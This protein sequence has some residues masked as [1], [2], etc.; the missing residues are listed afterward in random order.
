MSLSEKVEYAGKRKQ[1]GNEFFQFKDFH[2]ALRCYQEANEVC[3]G[4]YA[5]QETTEGSDESND[6]KLQ[7]QLFQLGVDCGNNSATV[8]YKQVRFPLQHTLVN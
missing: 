6:Q 4:D 1:K 2:H 7:R 3:A 8:L 5:W